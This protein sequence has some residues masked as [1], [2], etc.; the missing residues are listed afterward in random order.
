[1][2]TAPFNIRRCEPRDGDAAYEVCLR[3][4][5]DGEDA[6]RDFDDPMAL[7]HI[8]VGP[9]LKLE[10]QLA[11]VLE[12]AQ[13]VCGYVLG[14]LDS[15]RF[16]DAYCNQ[17]L[18]D[19]RRRHPEPTGDPACWT[20]TQKIYSDYY[21]PEIF[22]PEPCSQYPSHLHLDLLPRARG[23]GLGREMMNLLLAELKARGSAGVHLGMGA[24][25]TRAERFYKKLG[26]H[27]LA[28]VDDVLY[29]GKGLTSDA[30]RRT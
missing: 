26:F 28:R 2:I 21:H 15:K 8:F 11:F 6:S 12:D 24:A 25:N 27:E 18:P 10:P 7:G 4:G 22:I 19:I 23:R 17:W 13:G 1:M 5:N 20:R 16:Y 29:L 3:T 30:G 9:Y 14:A